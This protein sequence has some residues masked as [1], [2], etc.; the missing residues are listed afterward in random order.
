MWYLDGIRALGAALTILGLVV[1]APHAALELVLAPV[2]A[3][4]AIRRTRSA[5]KGANVPAPPARG[6]AHLNS[7]VVITDQVS[8]KLYTEEEWRTARLESE[9]E[10]L[11]NVVN[12]HQ[13]SITAS[14]ESVREVQDAHNKVSSRAAEID[15]K[16]EDQK[17]E[18]ERL[19]ASGFPLA[20]IGALIAGVPGAWLVVTS[21]DKVETPTWAWWGLLALGAVL[22]V[23]GV[24]KLVR[25]QSA[26]RQ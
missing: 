9:I 21:A 20:A 11:K 24:V 2:K 8:A 1:V 6:E 12:S 18:R 5:E 4:R 25:N 13:L 3:W 14:Q 15:R 26:R 16:V 7:P 22:F 17:T 10:E 23:A 19:D